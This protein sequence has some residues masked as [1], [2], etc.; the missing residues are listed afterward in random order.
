MTPGTIVRE[1]EELHGFFTGWLRGELPDTDAAF[2]RLTSA[3]A[4]E[5]RIG[6]TDGRA[7]GHA[8]VMAWLRPAH[9]SLAGQE[10][11]FRIRTEE[12]DVRW[13]VGGRALA[14]YVERQRLADR[15]TARRSLAAFRAEPAAPCGVL[16]TDLQECWITP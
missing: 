16:W 12:I 2:A 14:A 10:P 15:E 13:I 7:L 11:P 1:I 8:E 5:F 4:P 9:G 3:L 6:L